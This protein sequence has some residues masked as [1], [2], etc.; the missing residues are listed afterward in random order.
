MDDVLREIKMI[1]ILVREVYEDFLISES[2]SRYLAHNGETDN[3][4]QDLFMYIKYLEHANLCRKA[5]ILC[6]NYL[7]TKNINQLIVELHKLG[8]ESSI[9]HIIKYFCIKY[10]PN[11]IK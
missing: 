3:E 9:A 8:L 10:N 2:C 11:D 4:G 5:T 7:R 6:Q 1:D